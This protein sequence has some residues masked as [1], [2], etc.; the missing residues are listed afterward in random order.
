MALRTTFGRF[1][2]TK[3]EDRIAPAPSTALIPSVDLSDAGV[4]GAEHACKGLANN[5]SNLAKVN[6]FIRHG[7]VP[8]ACP[9]SCG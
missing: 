8:V 5:L 2:I 1:Q 6:N 4:N 3:L 7:C 9:C